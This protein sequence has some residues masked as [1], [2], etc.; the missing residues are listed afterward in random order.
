MK[1]FTIAIGALF[2]VL[3]AG[4]TM[5]TVPGQDEPEP[6]QARGDEPAATFAGTWTRQGESVR[7]FDVTDDGATVHG[8]L[9]GTPDESFASYTFDLTR[10]SGG[11]L[12]GTAR[13]ELVDPAGKTFETA[14][15]ARLEGTTISVKAEELGLDEAGEVAE[16]STVEHKYDLEVVAAAEP[17]AYTPPAMDMSAY[18][19]PAPNYKHLLG[20]E[21]AVGQWVDVEMITAA[22][23][24]VTRTAVVGD[25]GDAWILE[26]DN[27][28]NQKDLLLA[29]FVNK[30]TGDV[31]KAFVGSRGKDGTE[32][33]VTPPPAAQAGEAPTGVDEE[34]TVPAGTFAAKRYDASGSTSWI[35]AEGT[36]AAGVMLKMQ[37]SAGSDELTTLEQTT[38]DVGGSSFEARHL[39][40]TSGNDMTMALSPTPYLN[41]VMLRTKMTG[42]EMG[43][44]GQGN[45]AAP[46]FNY[47]R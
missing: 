29:V 25:A 37:H 11:A 34:V 23:K 21:T 17:E 30:D 31:T 47:P 35:G 8:S 33:A 7:V 46:Q 9:R 1:G 4:C 32:K 27:Q 5:P 44:V 15:E 22:G 38:V 43:L 16:R 12:K 36:D 39:V 18:V 3:I 13:F 6:E 2:G 26:L 41:Q 45:D 42:M 19:T 28:M 20:D 24:S 14:W 40:Y 10:Q